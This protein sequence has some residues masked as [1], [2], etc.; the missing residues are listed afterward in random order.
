M[1]F[2]QR[3]LPSFA[4]LRWSSMVESHPGCS[5]YEKGC[6]VVRM[7][8]WMIVCLH[9]YVHAIAREETSGGGWKPSTSCVQI[10][11]LHGFLRVNLKAPS[12]FLTTGTII[13]PFQSIILRF[14]IENNSSIQRR[15][16]YMCSQ[17]QTPVV[18]YVSDP[19]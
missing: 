4:H 17:T 19:A 11:S 13:Q 14:R 1:C 15:V 12:L 16:R 8:E 7:R 10:L 3:G 6:L 9:T 18:S 2:H 5:S